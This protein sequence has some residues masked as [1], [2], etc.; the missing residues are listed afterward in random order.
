MLVSGINLVGVAALAFWTLR[1]AA[2]DT[3]RQAAAAGLEGDWRTATYVYQGLFDAGQ[4]HPTLLLSLAQLRVL[5]HE[6]AKADTLLQELARQPL[7]PEQADAAALLRGWIALQSGDIQMANQAWNDV[8]PDH[9]G[10][11]RLLQVELALRAGDLISATERLNTVAPLD[12]PW[13][14]Y[15]HYRAAQLA[16]PDA[17]TTTLQ[18]LAGWQVPDQLASLPPFD[19]QQLNAN[20]DLLLNASNLEPNAR[21]IA[22]ARMWADEGLVRAARALLTQVPTVSVYGPLARDED[23]RLRWLSGDP[24]GALADLAQTISAYPNVPALRR[25]QVIIAAA[26]GDL[27]TAKAALAAA[28]QADGRSADNYVASAAVALAAQDFNSAAAAYDAAIQ[29]TPLTGTY[30]LQAANFYVAAPLR[31]CTA[32]RAH[33]Q[34]AL[35]S[36]VDAAARRLAAQLALRCNDPTG[37][38]SITAPLLSQLPA[39]PQLLY[40]RGAAR[41]QLGQ[42]EAARPD[43]ERAANLAPGSLW[44]REAEKLIGKP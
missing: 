13:L 29:S 16:L 10:Q 39:D 24:A 21:R 35:G 8:S 6:W 20:R 31:V 3:L 4:R 36:P 38:I 17:P 40:V 15:A 1:P 32:G 30:H 33:A 9:Q 25:T 27:A 2:N 28:V 43:L 5:R 42:R 7:V 12:E 34:Q 22:L 11:A 23:A 18:L 14:T 19:P 26:A 41:W 44:M 37:A